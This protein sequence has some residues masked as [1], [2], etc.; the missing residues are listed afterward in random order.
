[1]NKMDDNNRYHPYYRTKNYNND[2]RY[3][4]DYKWQYKKNNKHHYQYSTSRRDNRNYNDLSYRRSHRNDYHYQNQQS[5]SR[6]YTYFSTQPQP[7]MSSQVSS[8]PSSPSPP[9]PPP[10]PSSLT[11]VPHER[12]SWIRSVKKTKM[13]ES[14]EQKTQY[15]ETMLRMPQQQ[16]SLLNSSRFDRMRF[17]DKQLPTTTTITNNDSL[18]NSS[19]HLVGNINNHDEIFTIEKILFDNELNQQTKTDDKCANHES[20]PTPPSSIIECESTLQKDPQSVPCSGFLID[21]CDEE[22]LP[23]VSSPPRLP[24]P[25]LSTNELIEQNDEDINEQR[26]M[27]VSELDAADAEQKQELKRQKRLHKKL[28]RKKKETKQVK[29]KTEEQQTILTVNNEEQESLSDWIIE[30][31]INGNNQISQ[32]TDEVRRTSITTTDEDRTAKVNM[33]LMKIKKQ[34]EELRKLRQYVMSM[35]G[36]QQKSQT[37]KVQQQNSTIDHDLLMTFINQPIRSGCWLCSGKMYAEAAIQ[38]DHVNEQ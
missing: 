28:Q 17:A 1:M 38:C 14:I 35:L 20:L 36:E 34:Q 3:D 31:D 27:L 37:S 26:V 6:S 9:P 25:P 8:L 11:V 7:L 24:L 30:Y 10:L 15:L 5:K 12:E 21:N 13:N 22:E 33:I 29:M 4:H 32:L 18:D 2:R 16:K 23:P 19:F